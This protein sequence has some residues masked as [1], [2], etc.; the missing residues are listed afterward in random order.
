MPTNDNRSKFKLIP[1]HLEPRLIHLPET[2]STNQFLQMLTKTEELPSGS[3]VLTDF[4]TAGRGQ[5]G[6]SWES[7][8]GKNLMFSILFHPVDVPANMPFVISE[9][10]SLSV[11]YTHLTNISPV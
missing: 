9:M 11:K 8:A 6:N 1:E 7:E 3:I 4:Q 10:V 5:V 2:D